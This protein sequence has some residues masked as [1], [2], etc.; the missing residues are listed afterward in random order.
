MNSI[1]QSKRFYAT[2]IGCYSRNTTTNIPYLPSIRYGH[3]S[4]AINS[5]VYVIG[6]F[7]DGD[8]SKSVVR[9]KVNETE[10]NWENVENMNSKRSACAAAVHRDK[11]FVFGGLNNE[12]GHLS[13]SNVL[14]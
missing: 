7:D 2:N 9:I 3:A 1:F 14:I 4:V 11:I 8:Y 6:G 10:S 5:D 13:L 12:S